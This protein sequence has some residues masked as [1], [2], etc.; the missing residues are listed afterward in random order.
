MKKE[1]SSLQKWAT[2]NNIPKE[3][4]IFGKDKGPGPRRHRGDHEK[5]NEKKF[6]AATT[7]K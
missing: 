2:D 4:L 5:F 1:M 3:Y 7:I 6:N